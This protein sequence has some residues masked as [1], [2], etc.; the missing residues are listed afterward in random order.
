MTGCP[1][2]RTLEIIEAGE[3]HSREVYCGSLLAMADARAMDASIAIRTGWHDAATGRLEHCA[4]SGIVVDSDPESEYEETWAKGANFR[5]V[6][7]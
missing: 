4:G 2:R 3:P 1:K 5:E 7:T 6:C